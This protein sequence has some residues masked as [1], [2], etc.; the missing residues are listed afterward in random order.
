[1]A[2]PKKKVS[3][4][5]KRVKFNQKYKKQIPVVQY[6]ECSKCFNIKKKHYACTRIPEG[7]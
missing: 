5:R 3:Y 7:C 1:M 6:S 4:T 2:V